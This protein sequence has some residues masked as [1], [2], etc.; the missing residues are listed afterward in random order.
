MHSIIRV[1]VRFFRGVTQ[2]LNWLGLEFLSLTER[3]FLPILWML[4]LL[5]F[6]SSTFLARVT[7]LCSELTITMAQQPCGR[8]LQQTPTRCSR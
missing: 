8:R 4:V 7:L 2:S 1:P 6:Q 5:R 3:I